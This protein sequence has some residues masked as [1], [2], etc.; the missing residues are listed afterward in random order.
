[1]SVFYELL[2]KSTNLVQVEEM[3][4]LFSS[5]ASDGK[6]DMEIW[7]LEA[8]D[9][10]PDKCNP[11]Q[12]DSLSYIGLSKPDGRED[13]RFVEF[14]YENKGCEG[15]IEPFFEMLSKKLSDDGKKNMIIVPRVIRNKTKEFWKIY[16][17]KY[18]TDI[19]SGEKF[20]A[21]NKIPPVLVWN[22]LTKIMPYKPVEDDEDVEFD[23]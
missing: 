2:K 19:Q 20:I 5:I 14:F 15:I 17:K 9:S 22:E 7:G 11:K 1:M 21:K 8:N 4:D 13:L 3:N 12:F 23:N 6:L 16:L 10:F 18:F